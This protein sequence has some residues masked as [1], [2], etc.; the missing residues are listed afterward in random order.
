M[1]VKEAWDKVDNILIKNSFKCC[2]ISLTSNGKKD[3]WLFNTDQLRESTTDPE[4]INFDEEICIEDIEE[5]EKEEIEMEKI[6]TEEM[7]K[8]NKENNLYRESSF[9]ENDWRLFK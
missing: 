4:L 8:K 1:W 2:E 7:E 9:S 5:M 6:K 3:S